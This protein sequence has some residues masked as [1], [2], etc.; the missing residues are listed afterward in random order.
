MMPSPKVM[1]EAPLI[2]ELAN[3]AHNRLADF[4][5]AAGPTCCAYTDFGWRAFEKC[6]SMN[7]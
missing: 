5:D 6:E 7:L 4:L 1:R 3:Y 2:D